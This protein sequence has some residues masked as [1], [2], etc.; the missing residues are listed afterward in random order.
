MATIK[1]FKALRPSRDLAHRIAAL[2]YDV[3]N[4][5]EAKEMVKG[6]D[7]SFL[8]IDRAEI[9][10]PELPD[11]HEPKVYARGRE[12]LDEMVEQRHFIQDEAD[13]LYIYRQIM[14][15]RAQ[16]GLVACASIDDYKN[17]IIK[18][19]EYTRPD[20]EQDRVDHIKA[21]H[22]QTGPIFQTY[23]DNH[24]ITRTMNEWIDDHKPVYQFIAHNVE[25][26]CW[27]VDCPKTIQTLVELFAELDHLYIADGHHRSAAAFR[28]GMEMREQNPDPS[29][30]FNYFLS[31]I[32][33]ASDLKIW[34]Y[35]RLV[36][37]L[38]GTTEEE[39]FNKVRA[40]FIVED[41]PTSPYSPEERQIFGMYISDQWYKLTPKPGLVETDDLIKDL[42]VAVLQDHL[43]DPILNIKDPRRD[44]RIQFVGGIRGLEELE[45]RVKDDMKVAFSMYPTSIDE[46]IG[47]A[48]SNQVMPPKSTWFEPKLLSGLFIH[49]L[50]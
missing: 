8:R 38:N 1:P 17:N 4:S 7:Y 44:E 16:T 40:K 13:C 6:N 49:K 5:V 28:V 42:D 18:K 27:V 22:A 36:I 48:D 30:E 34:P 15:G 47:V 32:F 23:R 31:V 45:R 33:P 10:F 24:Q 25:H 37:D 26:I 50:S 3:M 14:D 12:I 2:P 41:A 43:L 46:I 11:P 9:N 29:A 19:H 21:L 35:N 39:F 20:K